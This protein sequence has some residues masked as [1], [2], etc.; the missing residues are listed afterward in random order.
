MFFP[1]DLKEKLDYQL[2]LFRGK[3][4]VVRNQKREGL[5]RSRMIGASRASGMNILPGLEPEC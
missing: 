1:G 2:E 5:I 4:K 3:I